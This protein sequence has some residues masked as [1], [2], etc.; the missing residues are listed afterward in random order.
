MGAV[1]ART[2]RRDPPGPAQGIES[3]TLRFPARPLI[4]GSVIR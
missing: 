2:L 3:K 4:E 1:P